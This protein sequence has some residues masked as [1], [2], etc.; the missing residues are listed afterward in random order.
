[1]TGQ[2]S[3][4]G[5]SVKFRIAMWAVAGVLV[6]VGWA[7]YFAI[8]SKDVPINPVVY[9]LANFS[10]PIALVGNHFR[11]GVKLFWVLASNAAFYALFGLILEPLRRQLHHAK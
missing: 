11:F 7:I 9:T 10:C 8:L 3:R 2:E 1:M 5:A 4:G 6:A